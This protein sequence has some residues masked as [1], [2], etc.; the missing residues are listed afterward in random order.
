MHVLWGG[1]LQTSIKAMRKWETLGDA[2]TMLI[3]ACR[4]F[5]LHKC[6]LCTDRL[7][8]RQCVQL[9]WGGE[10]LNRE[11]EDTCGIK[12]HTQGTRIAKKATF[13]PTKW[14]QKQPLYQD[15][16]CGQSEALRAVFFRVLIG[17]QSLC[18]AR[19]RNTLRGHKVHSVCCKMAEHTVWTQSAQCVLQRALWVS[20]C[21]SALV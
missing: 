12:F 21:A 13:R 9:T 2:N 16:G 19:W 15:A 4:R 20:D 18:V 1:L 17:S 8:V 7:L 11:H 5:L 6:Q 3:T 14:H 10:Y